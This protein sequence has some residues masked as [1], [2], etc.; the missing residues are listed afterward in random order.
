MTITSIPIGVSRSRRRAYTRSQ[1]SF[2]T[3]VKKM[4][5]PTIGSENELGSG[6]FSVTN[7]GQ[8]V[9]QMCQ[10]MVPAY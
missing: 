3:T 6:E 8:S 9:S 4:C 10:L 1:P 7:L 2:P 5:K